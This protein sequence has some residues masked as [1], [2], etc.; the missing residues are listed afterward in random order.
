MFIL[1]K[2]KMNGKLESLVKVY[3]IGQKQSMYNMLINKMI[4]KNYKD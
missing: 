1:I 4:K 2:K 3:E